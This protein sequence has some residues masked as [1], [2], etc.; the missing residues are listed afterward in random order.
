VREPPLAVAVLAASPALRAG[1]LALLADAGLEAVAIEAAGLD[2]P[3]DADVAVVDLDDGSAAEAAAALAAESG[4]RLVLLGGHGSELASLVAGAPHAR[5]RRDATA[6]ELA[7]AAQAVAAG[8]VVAHADASAGS[9]FDAASDAPAG[10]TTEWSGD[11]ALTPREL[12]V[13]RELA[14]GLPN[15]AVARALGISEHTVKYH[16]GSIFAKLGARSRTEAVTL[17]ARRGLL[18]L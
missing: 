7:A 16:T 13:L 11:A 3:P 17:A 5:L 9:V 14:R 15:K 1:L 4:L 18:A 10:G 12:D 2:A 8:L 6:E